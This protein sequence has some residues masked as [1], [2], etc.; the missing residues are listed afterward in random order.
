METSYKTKK[1]LFVTDPISSKNVIYQWMNVLAE[2]EKRVMFQS[3]DTV[4]VS[5]DCVTTSGIEFIVQVEED[6]QCR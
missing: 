6:G 4:D 3:A 5:G 2:T 1:F